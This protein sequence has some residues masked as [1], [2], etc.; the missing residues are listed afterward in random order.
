[1]EKV[2]RRQQIAA[3]LRMEKEQMAGGHHGYRQNFEFEDARKK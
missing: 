3:S 1:M 2:T